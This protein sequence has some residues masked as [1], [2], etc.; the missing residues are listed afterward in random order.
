MEHDLYYLPCLPVFVFPG[1]PEGGELPL[2]QFGHIIETL[3]LSSFSLL[4]GV[5]VPA[6]T[7][8][9]VRDVF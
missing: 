8:P 4:Y 1:K 7:A 6:P 3:A 2:F 5:S 9:V